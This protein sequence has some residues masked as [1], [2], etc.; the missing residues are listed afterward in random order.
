M[1][2]NNIHNSA[3]Q[4]KAIWEYLLKLLSVEIVN[5]AIWGILGEMK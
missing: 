3:L 5:D 2:V 4:Q 1:E